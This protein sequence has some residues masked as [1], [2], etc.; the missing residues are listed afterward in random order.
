MIENQ[1]AW[2]VIFELLNNSGAILIQYDRITQTGDVRIT[3]TGDIRTT[4]GS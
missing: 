1:S 4:N 3:Q 2:W